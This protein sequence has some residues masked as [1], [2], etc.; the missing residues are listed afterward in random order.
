MKRYKGW[1]IAK[2]ISEGKIEGKKIQ[3]VTDLF[4]EDCSKENHFY[5]VINGCLWNER[6]IGNSYLTLP[7]NEFII[8]QE[9]VT[10]MDCVN[11]KGEVR[12][13]HEIANKVFEHIHIP[14]DLSAILYH[15]SSK[16]CHEDLCEVIK[17]GKWYLEEGLA[18]GE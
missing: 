7:N 4:Q 11:S 12:I 9:P 3:W 6:E 16:L 15:L 8:I 10:F 18:D 2:V 5:K 1:E 14:S 13:D 17:N